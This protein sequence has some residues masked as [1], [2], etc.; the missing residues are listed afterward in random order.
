MTK[1]ALYYD[2]KGWSMMFRCD[3]GNSESPQMW[4]NPEGLHRW[5]TVVQ[6]MGGQNASVARNSLQHSVIR[7]LH[8]I[9]P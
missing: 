9:L 8:P 7:I 2:H 3:M 1:H 4:T 5:V 6:V